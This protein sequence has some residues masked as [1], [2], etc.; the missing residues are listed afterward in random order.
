MLWRTAYSKTIRGH[1][2]KSDKREYGRAKLQIKNNH[3]LLQDV[4]ND[5][6][7]W[8]SHSDTIV[9]LPETFSISAV[10]HTIPVAAFMQENGSKIYGLQFHP[11][12]YHSAEG[13]K[14]I[15]NF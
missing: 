3:E 14:I 1:G 12:V 8:M 5:S 9:K 10:T 7:V 4:K 15:K 11:E 2:E 13:K 6:D